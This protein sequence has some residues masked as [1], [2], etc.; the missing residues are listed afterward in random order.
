MAGN[1]YIPGSRVLY[2]IRNSLLYYPYYIQG[3]GI[4]QLLIRR[5]TSLYLKL[6][7]LVIACKRLYKITYPHKAITRTV[8][9]FL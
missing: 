2:G 9:I 3:F 1:I 8:I 6:Y 4:M 5:S 7:M